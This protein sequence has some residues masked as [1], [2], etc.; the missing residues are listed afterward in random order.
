[1]LFRPQRHLTLGS[2][3]PRR[4][5]QHAR[6]AGIRFV[7]AEKALPDTLIV[8]GR[9]GS[10]KTHLL[11]AL[12]NFAKHNG[13]IRGITCL[14]AVQFADEVMRGG[15]YRDLDSVLRR[16]ASEGLLAIDDVECLF[17]LPEVATALLQVMQMRQATKRRTLLT[18]T[19]SLTPA[20]PHPLVAFLDHQPAVRL[21]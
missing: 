19:L 12:A 13:A 1:M 2:F 17:Y 14:A 20:P 18:T 6:A 3:I 9:P 7:G 16:Y 10:G 8:A 11:H 21:M 4:G 15:Y 5:N